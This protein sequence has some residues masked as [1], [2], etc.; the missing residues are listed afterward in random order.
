MIKGDVKGKMTFEDTKNKTHI[1]ATLL[2][3]TDVGHPP[4]G[5]GEAM[6]LYEN[7]GDLVNESNS[8]PQ[9]VYLIPIKYLSGGAL[10]RILRD[11]Q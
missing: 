10:A 8:V 3:D 9:T 11:I 1:D 6:A 2:S 7:I 4:L 5:Y